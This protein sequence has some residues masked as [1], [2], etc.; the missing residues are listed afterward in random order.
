MKEITFETMPHAIAE[1][2]SQN[3]QIATLLKKVL[4]Q[5]PQPQPQPDDI[6]MTRQEVAKMFG[7]SL[8]TVH[9][10]MTAGIIKPYKLGTKTRFKRAEVMA[11]PKQ[12]VSHFDKK[13]EAD[14]D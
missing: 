11:A 5:I 13:K 8:P 4:D 9:A 7:I 3:V 6:W 12:I 1:L 2:Q 10:W 14:N